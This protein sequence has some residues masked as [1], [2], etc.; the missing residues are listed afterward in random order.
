MHGNAKCPLINNT[1]HKAI[2]LDTCRAAY[3]HWTK[4]L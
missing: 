4:L 1:I 3:D 2:K